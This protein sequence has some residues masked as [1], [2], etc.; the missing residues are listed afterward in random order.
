MSD[1]D[2]DDLLLGGFLLYEAER[3][4]LEDQP[5]PLQHFD[6]LGLPIAPSPEVRLKA[7]LFVAGSALFALAFLGLIIALAK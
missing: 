1:L 6:G 4:R 5:D 2:D 3:Q 7:A